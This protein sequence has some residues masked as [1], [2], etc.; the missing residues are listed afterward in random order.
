MGNGSHRDRAERPRV[1]GAFDL[2][3]VGHGQRSSLIRSDELDARRRFLTAAFKV[4]VA[5]A[6]A[7]LLPRC[8]GGGDGGGGAA[9]PAGCQSDAPPAGA[10]PRVL[11]GHPGGVPAASGLYAVDQWLQFAFDKAMD[12]SSIV[13]GFRISPAPVSAGLYFSYTDV[14]SN[15]GLWVGTGT[16]AAP[17]AKIRFAYGTTYTVTLGATTRDTQGLFLDGNGDGV[18][19][20]AYS[21]TFGTLADPGCGCNA[22][23]PC[24]CQSD[25]ACQCV[26]DY[27]ACQL[28]RV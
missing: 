7:P 17:L 19:G 18:A 22:Y 20:D 5:G 4:C 10:P 25:C 26:G 13:A 12:R 21:F 2:A 1:L 8:D 3:H 6:V 24:G 15:H 14:G 23:N 28:Y 11:Y 27:C 16:T 9:P